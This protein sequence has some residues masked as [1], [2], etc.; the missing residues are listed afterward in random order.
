V[1]TVD[2]YREELRRELG[3]QLSRAG[4]RWSAKALRARGALTEFEQRYPPVREV[5]EVK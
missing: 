3:R 4:G 1:V 5:E 2:G